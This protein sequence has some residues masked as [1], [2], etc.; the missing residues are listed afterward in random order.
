MTYVAEAR[1][2]CSCLLEK[3]GKTRSN[4]L[5]IVDL[6]KGEIRYDIVKKIARIRERN[7]PIVQNLPMNALRCIQLRFIGLSRNSIELRL[8]KHLVQLMQVAQAL[9]HEDA[10]RRSIRL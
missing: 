6:L 10:Q 3:H 4:I 1:E 8:W 7:R 5:R 2:K 9:D